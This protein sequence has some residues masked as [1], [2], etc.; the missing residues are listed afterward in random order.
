MHKKNAGLLNCTFG[1]DILYVLYCERL[2]RIRLTTAGDFEHILNAKHQP[3]VGVYILLEGKL[4]CLVLVLSIAYIVTPRPSRACARVRAN[5]QT[6]PNHVMYANTRPN[7][8]NHFFYVQV[9]YLFVF[10]LRSTILAI[11][12]R[13]HVMDAVLRLLNDSRSRFKALM[14]DLAKICHNEMTKDGLLAY[15]L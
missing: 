13:K 14:L 9:S 11:Q 4:G 1:G 15:F 10:C 6:I 3:P 5:P 12:E 8:S 2:W 7:A